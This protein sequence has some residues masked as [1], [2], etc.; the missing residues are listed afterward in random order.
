MSRHNVLRISFGNV[1]ILLAC[2]LLEAC[3]SHGGGGGSSNCPTNSCKGSNNEC[4]SC[5]TGSCTLTSGA[6]QDCSGAMNGVMCCQL[7]GLGAPTPNPPTQIASGNNGTAGTSTG[8]TGSGTAGTGSSNAGTGSNTTTE[9]GLQKRSAANNASLGE[10]MQGEQRGVEPTAAAMES[11][12]GCAN[13]AAWICVPGGCCD[14][15]VTTTPTACCPAAGAC[16]TDTTYCD[17]LTGECGYTC[18]A[19]QVD[20]GGGVC[21]PSGSTCM[22]NVCQLP[23]GC[24]ADEQDCGD[25]YCCPRGSSCVGGGQ[26]ELP[27]CPSGY[28]DCGEYCCETGS[29]CGG[30]G[31]CTITIVVEA[32]PNDSVDCG[33][34]C[35]ETGS[36]CDGRGGCSLPN[37]GCGTDLDCGDFCCPQGTTCGANGE[38]LSGSATCGDGICDPSE[39]DVCVD[40]AGGNGGFDC[41][42]GTS[43]SP[44]L[45]C[46]N[47]SDCANGADEDFAICSDTTNCCVATNGCPGETGNDCGAT[48][49]CCGVGEACCADLSGCCASP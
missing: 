13:G 14:P 36:T 37:G 38:C 5:A 48:C 35:C 44:D 34:Y 15:S 42:D 9:A 43:I 12:A 40:C 3:F 8:G 2:V 22:A 47:A 19:G 31:L 18:D 21:C 11:G 49:C 25:G 30:N 17:Y 26:C 10:T 45:V 4:F 32:C 7:A 16:C 41:G 33:S 28:L 6:N 20:C 39:I 1:L 23:P 46:N 27:G 24:A 29:E